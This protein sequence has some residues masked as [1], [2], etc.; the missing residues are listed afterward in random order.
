MCNNDKYFTKAVK[1]LSIGAFYFAAV[2]TDCRIALQY[3]LYLIFGR[4]F[5]LL[6]LPIKIF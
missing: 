6:A 3:I 4:I 1:L 2:C 5:D